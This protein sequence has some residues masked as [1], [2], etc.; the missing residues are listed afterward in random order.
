MNHLAT[1][2]FNVFSTPAD[3]AVDV[4]WR[5]GGLNRVEASDRRRS[6]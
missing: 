1:N 2:R 3:A 4:E 6:G 5:D